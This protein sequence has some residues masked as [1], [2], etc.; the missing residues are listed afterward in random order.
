VKIRLVVVEILCLNFNC[1]LLK[2]YTFVVTGK[3]KEREIV[4]VFIHFPA[5]DITY[6]K[7]HLISV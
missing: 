2:N 4:V 3:S 5:G 7:F 6:V 1:S